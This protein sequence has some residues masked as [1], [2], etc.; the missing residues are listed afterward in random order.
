MNNRRKLRK[1]SNRAL[2]N[3]SVLTA[4]TK[5]NKGDILAFRFKHMLFKCFPMIKIALALLTVLTKL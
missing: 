1:I 3:S 4:N 2:L 5:Q